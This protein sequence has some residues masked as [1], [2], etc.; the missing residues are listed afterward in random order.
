MRIVVFTAGAATPE[1][2][3]LLKRLVQDGELEIAAVFVDRYRLRSLRRLKFLLK[4]WGVIEF[5]LSICVV[6]IEMVPQIR[7]RVFN[8]WHDLFLNP[9]PQET[10]ESFCRHHGVKL[11]HVGNINSH[12]A[13]EAIKGLQ[14][15]LGIILGGR[16]LSEKIFRIPARGT[17]NIHGHDVRKY[18]GGAQIGYPER[19]N[20]DSCLVITIHIASS[21]VDAG[22]VLAYQEIEIE[23]YDTNASLQLKLSAT[24]VEFYYKTIKGFLNGTLVPKRQDLS[25]GETYYS[26]PHWRRVRL[27]TPI[28]RAMWR[29]LKKENPRNINRAARTAF[30]LIRSAY[31]WLAL[32]WLVARLRQFELKG[33]A[34][35]IIFYYHGVGNGA[36]NWM[37]LPIEAL[38]EQFAYARRYYDVIS[39]SEAVRRLKSG[40]NDKT[41]VVFTFDDGY[42]SCYKNLLPFCRIHDLPAALFVCAESAQNGLRLLHDTDKGYFRAELL[43]PEE[44][45]QCVAAGMEVG[46][47]SMKHEIMSQ[48]SDTEARRVFV[49]SKKI[50]ETIISRRIDFFSFPVGH[51]GCISQSNLNE[52]RQHYTAV[53]SAYGGYNFPDQN[54]GFYF[55]RFSN[56]LNLTDFR[57]ICAG[58]HRLRPFYSNH[59]ATLEPEPHS[60][61]LIPVRKEA[62]LS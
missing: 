59:P 21:K 24:G 31:F 32:P 1:R 34:P 58:V 28:R 39:L 57:A 3:A 13:A 41:S 42:R 56:P 54:G 47:H 14:P 36:E 61:D 37:T 29:E 60:N 16:I 7:K 49:E 40:H 45:R 20:G 9:H 38:S 55:Q 11:R 2:L 25:Q 10:Y 12:E 46:S 8:I 4:K 22:D 15:E 5:I 6:A 48:L 43:S 27:W 51:R 44:I 52:A 18:R 35:I 19:L 17:L 30:A 26:T 62:Q 50:L 33:K 53:F 23:K